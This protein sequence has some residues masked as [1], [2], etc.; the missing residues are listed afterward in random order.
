MTASVAVRPL[1]KVMQAGQLLFL[2]I[3]FK[4]MNIYRPVCLFDQS[5]SFF[6]ERKKVVLIYFLQ[7]GDIK[8]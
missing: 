8:K 1:E 5:Q 6:E 4:Y 3:H 2:G 7:A